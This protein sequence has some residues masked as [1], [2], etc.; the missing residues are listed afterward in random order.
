MA[1]FRKLQGGLRALV[2][3]DQL[4]QELDEELDGYLQS[5]VE[6]KMRDGMAPEDALRT[7]R[8]EMG[9]IEAVKQRVLSAGW[10]SVAETLWLDLRHS[11]RMLKKSPTF[12][13]IAILSLGLGIGANTAIFTLIHDLLLKSLPVRQPEQLVSFGKAGGGGIA[14]ALPMGTGGLFAYDFYRHIEK[15]H[16]FFQGICASASFTLPAS[17]RLSET[18]A[19]PASVAFFQLVSG[20]YFSVLD[21]EPML[22]RPILESDEDAPG[23]SAV[24][25][26]SYHYWLKNMAGD[27]SVIGRS[28]TLDGMPFMAVGVAP[29]K[30]FGDKLE[31]QAPDLWLPLTMQEQVMQHSSLLTPRNL[32]WL[33]LMGRRD[34]GMRTNQAQAWF[35]DQVQRYMSDLEGSALA[36]AHRDEIRRISV[37]LLPGGR[38]IS[39]L[40]QEYTE[41]LNVLMGVVVLVLLIACANLASFLLAKV[42]SR[43]REISIRLALGSSRA[44]VIGQILIETLLLSTF[45]GALGL[46]LASWGT[47]ALIRFVAQGATYT[48]LD[49]KPDL[50]VLAFTLGISLVT[51]ILFG[52]APAVR[53]SRTRA[54]ASL[55]ANARTTANTAG[56]SGR[57]APKII[58]VAQV[59]LSLTLLVGAGLFLRTLRNL[60]N[61]DLGFNHRNLLMVQFLPEAAGYKPAQ[62]TGFYEKLLERVDAIPGVHSAT[63]SNTPI[64]TPANWGSPI[65]IQGYPAQPN[66]DLGTLGNFVT[67]RYFETVGIPVLRGRSIEP[68]DAASSLKVVVVNQTF[69]NRFFPHGDALGRIFTIADP[70][71]PG[72]WEIVGVARDAMYIG[73]REGPQPMIYLPVTQISGPHA[74]AHWV[75][76]DTAADPSQLSEEV[77]RAVAQVDV[78]LSILKTETIS[79]QMDNLTDHEQLLSQLCTAFSLLALLLATIGL[80]GVMTYSVVRRTN[81]IGVRM[82]LGAQN[83]Q[84]VWIVLKES[85]LLY[86]VGVGAGVPV[87]LAATRILRTRLFGLSPFDPLTLLTSVLMMGIVTLTAA[88]F[89]ARRAVKVDPMVALR[90]E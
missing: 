86:A 60:E 58:V 26:L 22:G 81:E 31:E 32:Y 73:P 25:V 29:P 30:F 13:A 35:N 5:A 54:T 59:A 12:T 89:P 28:I 82:A 14:G 37:P 55:K 63:L 79:Q 7:T 64:V 3:R 36:P 85:L 8:V 84:V 23:R 43:E 87:T 68:E 46:L 41:P 47:R 56:A 1:W 6:A 11:L 52:I 17:L 4:I 40:R 34:A 67:P 39:A 49:P 78:N 71:V 38:G 74:Y 88:S 69:A 83:R 53:A 24:A 57:L 70:G 15:Q 76:I 75:L 16:E 80:Y 48:V 66:Q 45:G 27:P 2:H 90:H 9:S 44:R 61:Q 21:V 65:S 18:F 50:A 19:K 42:V 72:A 20:N 51:A 10:E 77:R 62:L 33:H